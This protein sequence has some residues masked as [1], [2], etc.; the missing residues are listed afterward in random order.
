M[1]AESSDHLRR[2]SRRFAVR[3]SLALWLLRR[4]FPR[5]SVLTAIALSAAI[6]LGLSIALYNGWLF[7]MWIRFPLAAASSGV[8]FTIFMGLFA[9]R[10]ARLVEE[11]REEVRRNAFRLQFHRNDAELPD[12]TRIMENIAD[13]AREAGN[14]DF[15]PRALQAYLL[16]MLSMTVILICVYF[17][18]MAPVLLAD[19]V[20][21]GSLVAWLYRPAFR[22]P[23]SGW[24]SAVVEK[25][26]IPALVLALAF[27][28]TG[29]GF[30]LY[31]PQATTV[32]EVW[33][34]ALQQR[35]LA[36]AQAAGAR[37]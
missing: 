19:V 32:A 11:G 17:V 5:L 26:A 13:S 34:H 36:A 18:W 23:E 10:T 29:L 2:S 30:Q 3:D 22:T 35:N 12:A 4:R 8:V 14:Q 15:D 33:Q 27:A 16:F 6:G 24:L 1:L 7:A 21:E 31:A 20:V 9:L 25:T 37:R 28:A